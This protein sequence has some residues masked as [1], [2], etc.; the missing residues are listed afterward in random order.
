MTVSCIVLV[1]LVKILAFY[2]GRR[3]RCSGMDA[4]VDPQICKVVCDF[5]VLTAKSMKMIRLLVGYI[6]PCSLLE[7]MITLTK[8]AVRIFEALVNFN[9]TT[10]RYMPECYHIREVSSSERLQH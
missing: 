3:C 2:P 4:R 6:E 10:R 8:E 9:E 7:Y 5:H 1:N